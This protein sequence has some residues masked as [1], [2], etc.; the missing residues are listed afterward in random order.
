MKKIK[1]KKGGMSLPM[2]PIL[3]AF[4]ASVVMCIEYFI[5]VSS[6]NDIQAILDSVANGALRTGIQ[7]KYHKDE[8][9]INTN[10]SNQIDESSIDKEKIRQT[11]SD[12]L[13]ENLDKS[14]AKNSLR[15]TKKGIGIKDSFK[16]MREYGKD[17]SNNLI[18][19][20]DSTFLSNPAKSN[21]PVIRLE[22]TKWSNTYSNSGKILD[23]VILDAIAEVR[24][25]TS[26][27]I[28]KRV[29]QYTFTRKEHDISKGSSNTKF[30]IEVKN[31]DTKSGFTT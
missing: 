3:I 10:S 1:N 29:I 23:T 21:S 30:K 5:M 26:N 24:L 19:K 4:I 14:I 17:S 22:K 2:I 27:M 12:L 16:L 25:K 15:D 13:W 9:I 18:Y 31:D 6:L 20:E 7:H 11:Y 8:N 28:P